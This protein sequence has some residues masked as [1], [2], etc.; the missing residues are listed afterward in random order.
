[1]PNQVGAKLDGR[2]QI[3]KLIGEGGMADVYSAKDLLEDREV[4][5]KILKEEFR[6]NEELVRRFK[7]ESRAISVLNHPN[8][9]KVYDVN[10]SDK[11]QYIAM[12]FI[13]GIT[14][15]E[16]IEQRGEPLTYKETI[17]FITQILNALQHA[18]DK[19]IVHRDIK[20]QNIMLSEDGSVKRM[21][22]GIA[23]LA[24][25]E[26]HTAADQAI[27]SV[28]YISPEQAKGDVTDPRA[29][30]YSVG[31]MMY[32]ML[33]SRLPFESDNAVSI[34]IA[35][36]SDE[37]TPLKRVNPS[38]P[39]GLC[40]IV[41]KAMVKDPRRRY[42]NAL[43]MLR[44]IEEFKNDPSVKFEYDYLDDNAQTRYID[45]VVNDVK[46]TASGTSGRNNAKKKKKKKVGLLVPIVAGITLAVVGACAI[47]CWNLFKESGNSLFN[48]YEDIALPDFTGMQYEE[49][50]KM[51][52]K[53]PS[54]N[55]LR[56]EPVTEE[57]NPD[58]PAGQVIAQNPTSSSEDMKMVK[59]NQRIYLTISR[60]VTD[61]KIPEL[62]G[63]SRAEAVK[64]ILALGLRPYAKAEVNEGVP[65]GTTIGTVPAAGEYVQNLPDT[66]VT[67]LISSERRNYERTVPSV[68]GL[69]SGDAQRLLSG[70]DLQL[71]VQTQ[72]YDGSPEG[73]ILS[74]N[75]PQG[76]VRSIGGQVHVTVSMGPEPGPSIEEQMAMQALADQ[77]AAEAK[78]KAE[79]DRIAS[80]A[81]AA[82]AQAE[83]DRIAAEQAAAA[84]Q[85]PAPPAET[86]PA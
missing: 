24:R 4:A 43:E 13:D 36:I 71:G 84:Q 59:A 29:D 11:V 54:L 19:G 14:L 1:M 58:I 16:Y 20:P 44:D 51:L 46:R 52:K 3:E 75:P 82:A 72:V 73:T 25:S 57:D 60:G 30:I 62:S 38:I 34:A 65:A 12:E 8:I 53:D 49:V 22:F 79:S 23:R 5:V 68:V 28:H 64:Q 63:M 70:Q 45:K 21:D 31:I 67:I 55:Y 17:H 48:E 2:Y 86:P 47:L 7:N 61:V 27:G 77:Q 10:V 74:Q 35:Q 9:V 78:A 81:A 85:P 32:E 83:V 69:S 26:I 40:E 41:M 15:K 42:Q 6:E 76:T 33:S 18:H 56:L 66:V 39:D 37:A 80:D 50:E